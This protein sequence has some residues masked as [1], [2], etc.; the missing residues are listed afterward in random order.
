MKN[1][2]VKAASLFMVAMVV[3]VSSCEEEERLTAEDTLAISEESVSDA[4]FEDVDDLSSFVV[5]E[6]NY[7]QL[8]GR[9]AQDGRTAGTD[10]RITDC[11]SIVISF[12]EGSNAES[13][14]ITIDFGT[15]CTVRGNTRSGKLILTYS[16][17]PRGTIGF[18]VVTTFENY[19]INGIELKGTR[20]VER[21]AAS[22]ETNIKHSITLVDGEAI[23][24]N[25]GGTATRNAEFTR[26]W[27]RNP[28][29]EKVIVEGNASGVTRRGRNY[30]MNIT[31]PL[32]YKRACM[33][34]EGIYMAVQGTKVFTK[35]SKQIVIDYGDG[36]CDKEVTITVNGATR[37]VNIGN[38]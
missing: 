16:G 35:E 20:T 28:A 18:T 24:P 30:E 1:W 32:V 23:W 34:T 4:Y 12:S 25:N 2:F 37:S 10:E 15:G 26:E 6:G 13:G 9:V 31:D 14:V 22:I 17:G 11:S 33:L 29:D 5:F 19:K 38:N 7:E 8:G 27:V 3:L 21:I 36:E